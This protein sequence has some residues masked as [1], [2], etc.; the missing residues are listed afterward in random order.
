[1]LNL[2]LASTPEALQAAAVRELQVSLEGHRLVVGRSARLNRALMRRAGRTLNVHFMTLEQLADALLER[3]EL[4]SRTPVRDPAVLEQL[5]LG[6]V[7]SVGQERLP[8]LSHAVLSPKTAQ[9]LYQA[10]RDL[11]DS[12]VPP[13]RLLQ[14]ASH[15]DLV[16]PRKLEDLFKLYAL[17]EKALEAHRLWDPSDSMRLAA[18]AAARAPF[19]RDASRIVV[20]GYYDMTQVQFDFLEALARA[21]PPVDLIIPARLTG[22]ARRFHD[23]FAL[24]LAE[25]TGGVVSRV[26]PD[27]LPPLTRDLFGESLEPVADARVEV[28]SVS[29]RHDELWFC[30]K[31]ILALLDGG[32]APHGIAVLART[33]EPYADL[34][35]GVFRDHAIPFATSARRP[36][37]ASP[38]VK[39]LERALELPDLDFDRA[40]VLEILGSGFLKLPPGAD[41]VLWELEASERAIGRGAAA[42]RERATGPL[43]QAFEMLHAALSPL[44]AAATWRAHVA[45]VRRAWGAILDAPLDES[46]AQALRE[47][48]NY[49]AVG[50]GRTVER[51]R[52]VEA[53]RGKLEAAGAPLGDDPTRD[54][55]HVLDV[56]A[57]RGLTFRHLFL[58]G[59]N[60]K[61]FP[62]Y[63]HEEPFIRDRNRR[64]LSDAL[65]VKLE[66]KL[67]AIEEERLLF[68]GAIDAASETVTLVYQRA[69]DEGRPEAPSPYLR[70]VV[71]RLPSAQGRG[72]EEAVGAVLSRLPHERL[73]AVDA[74][75]LTP[76]ELLMAGGAEAPALRR[77]MAADPARLA[78]SLDF[79][80]EL[81]G[82]SRLGVLD[83]VIG[84]AEVEPFWREYRERVSP[85]MIETFAAC[86]AK[87]LFSRV[88][89]LE[90]F[91]R[92]EEL[93]EVAPNELGL[94]VHRVL[95]AFYRRYAPDADSEK[96]LR[97]V[98]EAECAVTRRKVFVRHD[99]E[100][101]V[102]T[103]RILR[104]LRRFLF[105]ED[106]PELRD[107]AFE[108]LPEQRGETVV[109]GVRFR[110]F[111]DRIV[112]AGGEAR[113]DD[114][115]WKAKAG[116]AERS[117]L[118]G[119][120]VQLPLYVRMAGELLRGRGVAVGRIRARLILLK[121]FLGYSSL[122]EIT[123]EAPPEVESELPED[124][125][126][127]R[128]AE[129][130]ATLATLVGHL[131]AGRFFVRP[132]Q[133]CGWCDFR[134]ACRRS[135]VPA[136]R[137][138]ETDPAVADFWNRTL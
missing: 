62:R 126:A 87:A 133:H 3:A 50:F 92:P 94:L 42:W 118:L 134:L 131:S 100:W 78:R 39:T 77:A 71:Y 89:D 13:D 15:E 5:I 125:W 59:L 40:A 51:E 35:E 117:A 80:R 44:P 21:G 85:T 83:G 116:K 57:A 8:F 60:E 10:I 115:K 104:A 97:E 48:E 108:V 52:F 41:P 138:A 69:D 46:V 74:M 16:E 54:A 4:A 137:R 17:Y 79:V 124:F 76:P 70:E 101:E 109:G 68:A 18:A 127:R 82:A 24:A 55:V 123:G 63:I 27:E 33:L 23:S 26:G 135:H 43:L 88:L 25:R 111:L 96:L 75:L 112:V 14:A 38:L 91:E 102:E 47:L 6:L 28:A 128:G 86:P 136:V 20:A 120:G 84:A 49:D 121:N 66:P 34:L 7:E 45:S 19:V 56:M 114:Y 81:E 113:V 99:V 90:R 130:E 11:K 2:V 105:E 72:F 58:I 22:P 36:L 132:E 65:G 98:W 53:L 93:D 122:K 30:A 61:V 110:G 103:G 31:R 106:L 73:R 67:E 32:A 119:E 37:R 95:E 9:A 29:G 12:A 1:M 129:F 64:V 107:L